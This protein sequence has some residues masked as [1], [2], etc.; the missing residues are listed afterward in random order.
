LTSKFHS[1]GSTRSS[2]NGAEGAVAD[3]ADLLQNTAPMVGTLSPE[4]RGRSAGWSTCARPRPR[5]AR[6]PLMVDIA[7][8]TPSSFPLRVPRWAPLER[9][10]AVDRRHVINA[11]HERGA[12]EIL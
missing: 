11:P 12:G 1:V 8:N 10:P 7:R 3:K 5:S 6:S 2:G 9:T 4:D